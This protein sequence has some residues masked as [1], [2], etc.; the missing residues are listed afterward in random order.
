MDIILNEKRV[1]EFKKEFSEKLIYASM[2]ESIDYFRDKILE[3]EIMNFS[4]DD[5]IDKFCNIIKDKNIPNLRRV[6]NATGTILHTNLGR[7]LLSKEALESIIEVSMGYSNLEFNLKDGSRGSRYEHVEKLLM[8]LTGSEGAVVVNNNAAAVFLVLNTL[9]KDKE[10]VVSR[11]ELVEIGGSFR[12]P[13]VMSYSGAKLVEIGTTNRTHL[14]DYENSLGENTGALLK[15]HTSNY[16]I[17]GF[18]KEVFVE[19]LVELGKEKDIPIIA[20][21]GSGT[22]IDFSKYGLSLE[23]TVQS[24]IEKGV[25]IVTFSGDKLLGGPQG[26]LIV[27]KKKWIEKIKKNQLIR[28]LRVDKMTLAALE[29]TLKAY[30]DEERAINNIPTLNMMISSKE[31]HKKRGEKLK[32]SLKRELNNFNIEISEDY[33]VVGGGSMPEEKIETYVIK[34][35]SDLYS[36]CQIEER[37]RNN[38]TPIITRIYKDYVIIDLR[39]IVDEDFPII[40]EAFKE[41]EGEKV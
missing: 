24:Y 8:D 34:I 26:G 38:K 18:T 25:D 12:I 41:I 16:K 32:R 36:S 23:P 17:L 13:E 35:K 33:S 15:V 9:C 21:I 39:T 28:A 11:G 22:L 27:G 14:R 37:L 40:V 20:D 4:K 3:E 5:I 30:L 1:I 2:K 7:A 29:A 6:I 31:I 19:E 10:A